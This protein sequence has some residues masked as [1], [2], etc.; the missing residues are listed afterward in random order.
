MKTV[1]TPLLFLQIADFLI[2]L[3][4]AFFILLFIFKAGQWRGEAKRNKDKEG[5]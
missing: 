4:L 2:I 3:V 5:K 1:L